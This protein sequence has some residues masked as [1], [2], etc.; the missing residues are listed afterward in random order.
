MM[1]RPY[2]TCTLVFLVSAF[3]SFIPVAG[4][5][6][7]DCTA[8]NTSGIKTGGSPGDVLCTD[9]QNLSPSSSSTESKQESG[10]NDGATFSGYPETFIIPKGVCERNEPVMEIKK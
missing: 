1:S 5:C 9:E 7:G 8:K 4:H 10:S 2:I 3:L 6:A